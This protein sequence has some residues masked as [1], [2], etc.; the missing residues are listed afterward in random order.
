M[1]ARWERGCDAD[2]GQATVF[3]VAALGLVGMMLVA[4]GPMGRALADR[5]QARTAADAAALAGAARGEAAA[6]DTAAA[7]GGDLVGYD[8]EDGE[9][10]VEVE[11]GGVGAFSRARGVREAFGALGASGPIG[12]GPRA[13]LAAPLVAA[14]ARADALLGRPVPVV[15]GFRSPEQQQALWERRHV[16][17]FPVAPPGRSFHERGLAVDVP[18]GFVDQLLTVADEAG[19]CQPLPVTDPVHF[20]LC[21]IR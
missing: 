14:L 12:S 3:G 5:A 4:L 15:S 18:S 10:V 19:L 20:E 1:D 13:G 6:R 2:R 9:V 16:N 8:V 7:N 21:G 11:V 17:P